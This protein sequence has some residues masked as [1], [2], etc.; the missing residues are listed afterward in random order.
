MAK[1]TIAD[2]AREWAP[3]QML[4]WNG[5]WFLYQAAMI[6]LVLVLWES[7]D[8]ALVSDCQAQIEVVLKAFEGLGEWSLAA[9]RSR[10]V[11][12]RIYEAGRGASV[13]QTSPRWSAVGQD[14]TSGLVMGGGNSM[15]VL[16]GVDD[17]DAHQIDANQ[18]PQRVDLH[19]GD[20]R[21]GMVQGGIWN[22]DAMFWGYFPNGLNMPF[23]GIPPMDYGDEGLAAC[24]GR[25]MM[26]Q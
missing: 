15:D 2:I 17:T 26:S 12:S 22:S 13:G 14:A 20:G 25:Y 6:P 8:A 1:Q 11:V 18:I 10:E 23:D 24:D 4:G 16:N 7:W 5:A 9:R 19:G 21:T 3:N